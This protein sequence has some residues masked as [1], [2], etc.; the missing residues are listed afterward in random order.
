MIGSI[1]WRP[2]AVL[3]EFPLRTPAEHLP[4]STEGHGSFAAAVQDL[5]RD[6]AGAVREGEAAAIGGIR[7][8]LPMQQAVQQVLAAERT[9]QAALAVRDKLVSS[10]LEISRMQI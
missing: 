6:T 4:R 8:E 9:V 2:S 5:L 3:P 10:F 1:G 7:A